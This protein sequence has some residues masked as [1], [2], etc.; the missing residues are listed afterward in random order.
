VPLNLEPRFVCT[1]S[2]ASW[3]RASYWEACV[4]ASC[5]MTR[6]TR[7]NRATLNVPSVAVSISVVDREGSVELGPQP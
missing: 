7:Q 5:I 1:A 6:A 3:S 2:Q 4:K